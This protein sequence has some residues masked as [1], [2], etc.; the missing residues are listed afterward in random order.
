[1]AK[2]VVSEDEKKSAIKRLK[3]MLRMNQTVYTV[4]RHRTRDRVGAVVAVLIVHKGQ[5]VN[6][7]GAVADA[8]GR[9]WDDR[10]GVW[11]NSEFGIIHELSYA[12][13][14]DQSKGNYRDLTIYTKDDFHA[15]YTFVHKQ[16]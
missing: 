1:M 6:I 13:H 8:I 15:G 14:G 11:T 9:Q 3:K 7:S 12:I 10:D 2:K 4:L 16:L 5:V